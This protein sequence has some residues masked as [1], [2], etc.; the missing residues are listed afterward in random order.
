MKELEKTKRISIS[1]V[2]FLLVLVIALLTYKK[3][4]Y[5]FLKSSEQTLQETVQKKYLLGQ[6]EFYKDSSNFILVDTRDLYE[7]NKSHLPNAVNIPL[8]DVLE[9]TAIDFL[10]TINDQG[11]SPLLYGTNPSEVVS[12]WMTLYQLGFES[13]KVLAISTKNERNSLIVSDYS[14]EKAETDYRKTLDS[15]RSLKTKLEVPTKK[16]EKKP[17]PIKVAPAPKKKKAAPEGG[18]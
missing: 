1:A 17:V 5:S 4:K 11:K 8:K 9:E 12:V 14:L 13:T 6:Q 18:C 16:V 7:F 15:L 3:P 10:K 2:I